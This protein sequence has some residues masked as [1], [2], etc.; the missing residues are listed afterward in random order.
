MVELAPERLDV[1]REGGVWVPSPLALD[2]RGRM[3]EGRQRLLTLYYLRAGARAVIPAAHTGEFAGDDLGLYDRWLALVAEATARQGE[4]SAFLMAAVGGA[5]VMQ[6][7]ETAA[8]HGYD[9]VMVAPTAFTGRDDD[10]VLELFRDVASVIPT[11]AFELQRAVPGSREFNA[12]LWRRLFEITYG[13]KGASFDTY[14]A[15]NM[16]EAAARSARRADLVLATGNDDRVVADLGGRFPFEVEG[17]EVVLRY[18]A[19]LLGHFATDTRAAV[20][21]S[22]AVRAAR[23]GAE[24]RLPLGEKELAHLVNMCNG[25]LFDALGN[26][27]NSVWGVKSRLTQ[28]G[29]LEAPHCFC[30]SGRPGLNEAIARAYAA[31]PAVN[32]RIWL[33]EELAKLKVEAGVS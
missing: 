4:G 5:H 23:D 18:A 32:D 2:E 33:A 31:H 22:D 15:Q 7:A 1:M 24:W 9:I 11:F 13:A 30:E 28:L 21:W 29:L 10:G 25:A 27:E 20:Q 26:F 16:L 8:R 19:G 6:Q 3:L 17:N 12:D 14:R